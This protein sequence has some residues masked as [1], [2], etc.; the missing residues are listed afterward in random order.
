MFVVTIS[1]HYFKDNI[2]SQEN[3][4]Y[5]MN[6]IVDVSEFL[7]DSYYE[8]FYDCELIETDSENN[9]E[10][11]YIE[12]LR[13]ILKTNKNVLVYSYGH[14]EQSQVSIRVNVK[15]LLE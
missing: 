7:L 9:Y 15:K 8:W 11:F 3:N 12:R 6:S 1:F 2:S 5:D 4:M 14:I 10:N 13:K